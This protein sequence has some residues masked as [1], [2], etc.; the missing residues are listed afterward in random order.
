MAGAKAVADGIEDIA[1]RVFLK[2]ENEAAAENDT[3]LLHFDLASAAVVIEHGQETKQDI[4]YL[5]HF[6]PLAHAKDIF[7]YEIVNTVA[8][9]NLLHIS[10]TKAVYIDPDDAICIGIGLAG[11]FVAKRSFL[12]RSSVVAKEGVSGSDM[13]NPLLLAASG[14]VR[15]DGPAFGVIP[16]PFGQQVYQFGSLSFNS[17]TGYWI[18]R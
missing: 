6:G 7:Y 13:L 11:F 5:I 2:R 8:C 14:V 1:A 9:G 3:D 10:L 4:F 16:G 12:Q 17:H 15:S 18:R